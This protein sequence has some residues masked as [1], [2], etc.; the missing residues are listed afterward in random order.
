MKYTPDEVRQLKALNEVP[1]DLE[2][3]ENDNPNGGQGG[4]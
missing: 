3:N 4:I 1:Q 2:I